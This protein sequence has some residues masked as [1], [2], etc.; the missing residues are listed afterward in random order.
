MTS[1]TAT[2]FCCLLATFALINCHLSIPPVGWAPIDGDTAHL[3]LWEFH[4]TD[5]ESRPIDITQRHPASKQLTEPQDA[6]IIANY[7]NPTFVLGG[8][9]PHVD[10]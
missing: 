5:L 7:S 9:T 1:W 6:E 3:H 4:S 10:Q 8:W 2:R